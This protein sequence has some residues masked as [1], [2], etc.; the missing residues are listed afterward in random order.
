MYIICLMYVGIELVL[1]RQSTTVYLGINNVVWSYFTTGVMAQEGVR[2]DGVVNTTAKPGKMPS[3]KIYFRS[4]GKKKRAWF[5]S[6]HKNIFILV[7][8]A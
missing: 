4:T 7:I 8:K 6:S 3:H 5:S 2:G 1:H